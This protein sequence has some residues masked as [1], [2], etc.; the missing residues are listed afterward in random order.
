M[1][2]A[3]ERKGMTSMSVDWNWPGSRW[4]RVDLHAHS[5]ESYDFRCGNENPGWTRWVESARD[6]GLHAIAVTDHVT[7]NGLSPLQAAAQGV[8]NAPVM[9]A[10]VELTAGDGSHLILLMDPSSSDTHIEDV[11]SRLEVHPDNRGKRTSRTTFSVEDILGTFGDD[12]IIVGAHVNSCKGL[13]EHGGE[14]RLNELRHPRLAAVEIDPSEQFDPKWI[15]GSLPEINR[16]ISQ[17]WASDGHRYEELGRRFTWVKMTRPNLEGLRLAL[18]DGEQS[19]KP[20]CRDDSENPNNFSSLVIE[21]I[22]V[23]KAQYIGRSSKSIVKFNP[24]LNAII[25]GRGTGKSTI[26]DFCRKTLERESEL[27]ASEHGDEGSLRAE[28]ERRMGVVRNRGE[29]GLMTPETQIDVA[30]RKDGE[31]FVVS[32]AQETETRSINRIEDGDLVPEEG[33]VRERFPVR[34]YGQKQLFAL[35]QDPDALLTV[36]DDDISVS[37]AALDRRL[38]QLSAQYLSQRAATR[39]AQSQTSDLP[40]RRAELADIERKLDILGRGGHKQVFET[41]RLDRQIENSWQ[42]VLNTTSGGVDAIEQKVFD[43]MVSDLN[44]NDETQGTQRYE[45]LTNAHDALR[46]VITGFKNA[47]NSNI[48]IVRSGIEE[49]K[50]GSD[51]NSWRETLNTSEQEFRRATSQLEQE[52]ISNPDAFDILLEQ[53]DKLKSAIEGLEKEVARAEKLEQAAINTLGEYRALRSGLT[54]RR[55]TFASS[56]SNETVRIEIGATENT[57]HLENELIAILDTDRF[58]DDRQAIASS[59]RPLPGETWDWSR[60]DATVEKI[61]EFLAEKVVTWETRDHRFASALRRVTPENI[62]RLALFL[63]NDTVTVQFNDPRGGGWRSLGHGSPGQ[64]T[65][66]LL[67]FVLGFGS[68]PIILDQPEDDLDN[69]LIYELLVT[70]LR[71]VKQDRQVIVVSH[72]PNIVVHGDAE[73]VLSLNATGGL[74]WIGC[75]GGLQE[76][77]VRDEICKVMEGG[78]EAFESRYQRIMPNRSPSN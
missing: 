33:N 20:A 68:E 1:K 34:V 75:E 26:V 25:G 53:S 15:D 48:S 54:Q 3:S 62:D 45:R 6:A 74:N 66:A 11:L 43:L 30:Y 16:P 36:I 55:E 13:L 51:A 76:R 4:W 60:L 37:K 21:S 8:D 70:R 71:E 14:Q 31:R 67:A 5:P 27:D 49:A 57:E 40:A 24:W 38:G 19:L 52:G 65:A 77:K 59:I 58:E 61:R 39:F 69:T 23:E 18:M 17:L 47:V 35:A 72:N 10:G 73:L 32:W 44:L 78:T 12:V 7:A 28:F 46:N 22:T 29:P 50:T 56:A 2:N 41:Y 42:N 9:Y 63:P 64:Q